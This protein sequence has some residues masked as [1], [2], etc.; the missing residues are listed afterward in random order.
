MKDVADYL[1]SRFG[2]P[3]AVFS[4]FCFHYGKRGRVFL[5]SKG[6]FVPDA[7][8]VFGLQVARTGKSIKPSTNL[9]QLFG[10]HAKRNIVTLSKWQ[11]V[12]YIRGEDIE[13]ENPPSTASDGYVL[14]KY[15]D[16]PIGCGL[17]KG[18]RIK[19]VLPKARR[20]EVRFI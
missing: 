15:M 1:K 2:I 17:L 7:A 16:F 5:S 12:A 14:L 18:N 4:N 11:A 9:L 8:I 3:D 10:K 13:F 6:I 19:N 20:M